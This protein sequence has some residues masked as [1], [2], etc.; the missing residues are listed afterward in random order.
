MWASDT[1]VLA[2]RAGFIER[3]KHLP[4][5]HPC[6]HSELRVDLTGRSLCP[7]LS[8]SFRVSDPGEHLPAVPHF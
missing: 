7:S 3:V 5:V 2:L 8:L 1:Y 6:L 4:E